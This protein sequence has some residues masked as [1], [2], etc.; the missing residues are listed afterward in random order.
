MT[1]T[2]PTRGPAF[3]ATARLLDELDPHFAAVYAGYVARLDARTV[4][5]RRTALL[6]RVGQLT[7]LRHEPGL[8][9]AITA[10]IGAEVA[11]AEVLDVILQCTVVAGDVVL[12]PALTVFRE[13]V[14]EA[15]RLDDVVRAQLPVTGADG[16][17]SLDA[18]AAEWD[19]DDA[20][21]P[22]RAA[23]MERYGW[24]GI[25]TG[26]R[27]RPRHMLDLLEYLDSLDPD[28]A[29]IWLG[30]CYHGL[31]SRGVLDDR[32]RLMCQ[33]ADCF[34]VGHHNQAKAHMRG[35]LRHGGTPSELMEMIFQGMV[36]LGMPTT[37]A[38]LKVLT[39]ILTEDGLLDQ[40]GSPVL[41][42]TLQ[43]TVG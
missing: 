4:L 37:F 39:G 38:A 3:E 20:A 27:L 30:Y 24:L 31:Y 25:S 9:D 16:T 10:A 19:P 8:R 15:G 13:V 18:E 11:A 34:A 26:L 12:D 33:A 32:T 35:V 42:A 43:R 22:R 29:A 41:S 21:D 36:H 1:S 40:L 7:C 23:L 14:V 6:V 5:D 17:R 2:H 28:F